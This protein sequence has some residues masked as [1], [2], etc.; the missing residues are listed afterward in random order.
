MTES[1]AAQ[2]DAIVTGRSL[3]ALQAALDLAEVGLRVAIAPERQ[4]AHV[5]GHAPQAADVAG[6]AGAPSTPW[7]E[8]AE[9]DFEGT[10]AAF[11]TRIAEPI[12]GTG[13]EPHADA[14]PVKL[15]ATAPLLR[16]MKNGWAPGPEPEVL[17][18]PAVPLA[19]QVIALIG[20]GGAI[21]AYFDRFTPL[22]TVGKTRSFGTLVRK[23][24]GS[25]LLRCLVQPQ[26]FERYG[27]DAG[28]VDAAIAAPGLNEALS[29]A[30][31][32]SA[33]V[34][35]YSDRNVARETRVLAAGGLARL[36]QRSLDK[37]E[38]YGA[39]LL[40]APIV[41]ANHADAGW[42]LKSADGELLNSR[43]L[44]FDQGSQPEAITPEVPLVGP[45]L[46]DAVRV[47]A[48]I[49]IEEP[50]WLGDASSALMMTRG[51][52]LTVERMQHASEASVAKLRSMVLPSG[53]ISEA[54][55]LSSL[56]NE[57]DAQLREAGLVAADGAQWRVRTAAAAYFE[58]EQKHEAEKRFEFLRAEEPML[59]AVG[60]AL[61]GDDLSVALASARTEAVALRRRLLGLDVD[62]A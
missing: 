21:R 15:P 39:V 60:R 56:I 46:P 54:S 18:I 38:L 59:L 41:D 19:A 30:G 35:A 8:R 3:P 2:F 29:R 32:L 36:T 26:I 20:A 42:V 33:A 9:F 37:L 53:G 24:M 11:M 27:V 40:A 50:S 55:G 14:L 23:R 4:A 10:I 17:G 43:S 51:W 57:L 16:D 45:L 34:L 13:T 31:A 52:A 61:H 49:D 28:E 12:E 1:T 5:A 48:E 58:I 22:L 6:V 62:P 25:R 47:Y 44:I 7:S